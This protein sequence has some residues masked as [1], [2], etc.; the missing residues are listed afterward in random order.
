MGG[1]DPDVVL[2]RSL[3]AFLASVQRTAR[4]YQKHLHFFCGEWLVLDALWNDEQFARAQQNGSIPEIDA[5]FTFQHKEGFIGLRMIVP[6]EIA[7]DP[8]DL[9]LIVVEFG[10][11]PR[12]PLLS[13]GFCISLCMYRLQVFT[14]R[15][16]YADELLRS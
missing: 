9:E 7:F 16:R 1:S 6:D 4:L 13:Q 3:S 15:S 2:G 10:N 5:K 12:L 11:D 14:L 8:D